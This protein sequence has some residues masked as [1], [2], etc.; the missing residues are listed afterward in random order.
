MARAK[1]D[2]YEPPRGPMKVPPGPSIETLKLHFNPTQLN[3]VKET[4]WARHSARLA[5]HTS[6]PE[7]LGSHPRT[8][9]ISLLFDDSYPDGNVDKKI[10]TL[11]EW[12]E[13]ERSSI[14]RNEASPPWLKFVWGGVS[15]VGFWMVLK[16]LSVQYTLFSDQGRVL[17][18]Q[19]E[20]VLEEVGV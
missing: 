10:K 3:L 16:R 7:F 5:E 6:V 19:C 17:R 13:P 1:L 9:T 4:H 11:T 20:L 8:L 14:R 12:C 2:A 15:T 18:A